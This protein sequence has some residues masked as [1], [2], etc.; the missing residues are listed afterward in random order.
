MS[1]WI[2]NKILDLVHCCEFLQ[3]GRPWDEPEFLPLLVVYSVAFMVSFIVC[4]LESKE[5]SASEFDLQK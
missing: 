4:K 2:N 5:I 1:F 3:M